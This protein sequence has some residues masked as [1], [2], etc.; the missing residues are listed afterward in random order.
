MKEIRQMMFIC[1]SLACRI[2]TLNELQIKFVLYHCVICVNVRMYHCV[3]TISEPG[4]P[5]IFT[6]D[7]VFCVL[8]VVVWRSRRLF[9]LFVYTLF[10][11]YYM[12]KVLQCEDMYIQYLTNVWPH[13]QFIFSFN[14]FLFNT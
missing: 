9:Y 13:L 14:P 4:C 10:C 3:T 12:I 5:N 2:M 7:G 6:A 11:A 8:N 1:L